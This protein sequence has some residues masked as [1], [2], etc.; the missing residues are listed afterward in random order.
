MGLLFSH[1]KKYKLKIQIK[2]TNRTL[3]IITSL[4][5]AVVCKIIL[6]YRAR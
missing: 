3:N 1:C 2:N 5:Y 6:D 4:L